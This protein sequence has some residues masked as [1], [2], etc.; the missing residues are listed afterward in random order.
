M[1]DKEQIDLID[2]FYRMKTERDIAIKEVEHLKK[3][4]ELLEEKCKTLKED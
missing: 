4:I 2:R 1:I 3:I